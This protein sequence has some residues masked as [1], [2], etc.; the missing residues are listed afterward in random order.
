MF[1]SSGNVRGRG[2]L[3]YGKFNT[4]RLRSFNQ[5]DIRVDKG[6]YFRKWS[7]MF[8]L[9]IQNVLNFKAELPDIL[10]NTQPDGSVIK[11]TDPEGN[12]RYDLRTISNTAGTILPS[13]GIMIDF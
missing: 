3:D 12:E 10:V 11:Y 4:L 6:F 2:Y 7:L 13:I 9:D 5:L 1:E 8:Y